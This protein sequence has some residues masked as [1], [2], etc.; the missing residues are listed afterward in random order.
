MKEERVYAWD[1]GIDFL[2]TKE[3]L[4]KKIEEH[5]Y[6]A[7]TTGRISYYNKF[8]YDCVLL[9]QLLNGSR[10][11][12]ALDAVLQ[13]GCT[14]ETEP[15][16]YVRKTRRKHPNAKIRYRKIVIPREVR[17]FKSV[18]EYC[19]YLKNKNFER[20]KKNIIEYCR[21][22]YGFNTHSLRYAF[23]TYM[24]LKKNV[25]VVIIKKITKHSSVEMIGRYVQT[26][27][28]EELLRKTVLGE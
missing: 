10:V 4:I 22:E 3:L 6:L 11:S 8:F 23:I 24:A 21:R 5:A 2:Q 27:Q 15:T 28:A 25:N 20:L 18:L 26:K 13:Y 9:T 16:V 12:E 14:G 1:K 19:M 17:K 7:R